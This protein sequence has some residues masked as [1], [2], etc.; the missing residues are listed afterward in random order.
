M[1]IRLLLLLLLT[2]VLTIAATQVQAESKTVSVPDPLKPWVGWVLQSEPENGCSSLAGQL[3]CLW[4]TRLDLSLEKQGGSFSMLITTEQ[5]KAVALPGSADAW[6]LNVRSGLGNSA[7]LLPVA[8]ASG[9][10]VV[11]LEPGTYTITGA[12]IWDKTPDALQVP[13]DIAL[14]VLKVDGKSVSGFTLSE[15]GELSLR[16]ILASD[17]QG[18]EGTVS[19]SVFRRI[20]DGIPFQ[21]TTRVVVNVSEERAQLKLRDPSPVGTR[22]ISIQSNLPHYQSSQGELVFGV[23]SGTHTIEFISVGAKPLSEIKVEESSSLWPVEETW[24]WN[25]DR[26][27]RGASLS[28]GSPIDPSLAGVP[29]EW[30]GLPA[31]VVTAGRPIKVN[32][33][34][35]MQKEEKQS[36]LTLQRTFVRDVDGGGYTVADEVIGTLGKSDR[37]DL[38]QPADLGYAELN[39][40]PQLITLNPKG[41]ERGVE[42]RTKTIKLKATSRLS[43]IDKSLP[44]VGW[45][46][47]MDW[48]RVALQSPPG[49][50]LLWVGG[51]DNAVGTRLSAWKLSTIFVLLLVGIVTSRILGILPGIATV[52]CFSLIHG[53]SSS[54]MELFFV[55]VLGIALLRREKISKVWSVV[56]LCLVLV[57]CV[58]AYSYVASDLTVRLFPEISSSELFDSAPSAPLAPVSFT[59]NSG[60][61]SHTTYNDEKIANATNA[62]MAYA[63]GSFGALIMAVFFVMFIVF[64][65]MR[66]RNAALLCLAVVIGSFCMRSM[67]STFFNDA[68]IQDGDSDFF[69]SQS[70]NYDKIV[71]ERGLAISEP[72][73]QDTSQA[74]AIVASPAQARVANIPQLIIQSG[75][76]MP[77]WKGREAILTWNGAVPKDH[78]ITILYLPRWLGILLSILKLFLLVFIIRALWRGIPHETRALYLSARR[79]IAPMLV[80]FLVPAV[81][82]E[83]QEVFPP[84]SMLEELAT[85]FREERNR[86]RP[87]SSEC[88]STESAT[89][90]VQG[91]TVSLRAIV[92]SV[93]TNPW[94]LPGA[95]QSIIFDSVTIDGKETEAARREGGI[96]WLRLSHGVHTVEAKSVL[97]D[98]QL[99]SLS[100]QQAAG[101]LV[102]E[103]EEFQIFVDRSG[104]GP[105]VQLLRKPVKSEGKIQASSTQM[106]PWFVVE[107]NIFLTHE[108]QITSSVE[109]FGMTAREDLMAIHLLPGERILRGG[110]KQGDGQV[111]IGFKRG[112]THDSFDG[113]FDILGDSL[114]LEALGGEKYSETWQVTCAEQWRC[115]FEGLQPSESF[116]DGVARYTIRP[117]PGQKTVM[118]F[119]KTE[120]ASGVT[121]SIVSA[122]LDFHP[123]THYLKANTSLV[124]R[125][126]QNGVQL[127]TLPE[128]ASVREVEID[129]Q[130]ALY[131]VNSSTRPLELPIRRGLHSYRVA[132][133]QP[134][135]LYWMQKL[136]LLELDQ[137]FTNGVVR[138]SIPKGWLVVGV[139]SEDFGPLVTLWFKLAI[140][141]LGFLLVSLILPLPLARSFALLLFVGGWGIGV[142]VGVMV[143]AWLFFCGSLMVLRRNAEPSIQQF[144]QQK[145][146]TQF[147]Y[148]F[149]SM[150]LL[151]IGFMLQ[152]AFISGPDVGLRGVGTSSNLLSWYIDRGI[153]S[154][155]TPIVI[156]IPALAWQSLLLLWAVLAMLAVIT[157]ILRVLDSG[158]RDD[159]PIA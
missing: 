148:L 123:S 94:A 72:V 100:F 115:S 157:V 77:Q 15:Y 133:T 17:G 55:A 151:Y 79:A 158:R 97:P 76:G 96:T 114:T 70:D 36:A 5:R 33:R 60:S 65:T 57:L 88:V 41:G 58:Q 116:K 126:G 135:E 152:A 54:L 82:V 145:M 127:V 146:V 122:E 86:E 153:G 106:T 89:L 147:K 1:R 83:A 155:P 130:D 45:S 24:I 118:K 103:A 9:S 74:Q 73:E 107:R 69:Q 23:S 3:M 144:L 84:E 12:F 129:G 43:Q 6:P 32:E 87:C 2:I 139:S 21:V 63:E 10:P 93:G 98:E 4:P 95:P 61:Y 78:K 67:M 16:D 159:S 18:R 28:G 113:I 117:E 29:A 90:S 35:K 137:P 27:I 40:E 26:Q 150:P 125:A 112:A 99:V 124:V 7:S 80:I 25:E 128:G 149:L 39:G 136:P 38:E 110:A 71:K 92:H 119:M 49:E 105:I 14:V 22:L 138:Y 109:R 8:S 91:Q 132:W 50:D 31:L 141:V 154:L 121:Q 85:R 47:D 102:V 75:P 104:Q 62:L 64:C 56:Y 81:S 111:V 101:R 131:L 52:L 37:L 46:R 48:L 120:G 140:G 30:A 142:G 59:S 44:A 19:L 134:A 108:G 11:Y 143:A 42:V 34:P 156:A 20:D 68:N 66:R 13:R 53:D 51:A